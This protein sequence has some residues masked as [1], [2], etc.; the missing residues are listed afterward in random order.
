MNDAKTSQKTTTNTHTKLKKIPPL[1]KLSIEALEGMS[2]GLY[3]QCQI[4]LGVEECRKYQ[5]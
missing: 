2:G 1:Q 5:V 4:D 3:D